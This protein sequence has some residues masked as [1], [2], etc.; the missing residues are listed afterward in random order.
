MDV[1]NAMESPEECDP[2]IGPMP[3]PQRVVEQGDRDESLEPARPLR[4][5][6]DADAFAHD[7]GR[8]RLEERRLYQRHECKGY[9]SGGEIAND[10]AQLRFDGATKRGDAFGNKDKAANDHD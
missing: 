7:P 3:P 6:E 1:V 2:V 5:L 9:S 4:E 8:D 10:A